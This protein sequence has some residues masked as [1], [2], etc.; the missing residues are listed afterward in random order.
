MDL[1]LFDVVIVLD[2]FVLLRALVLKDLQF[3]LQDFYPFLQLGQVLARV[4]NQVDVLVTCR[5]NLLVQRLEV[6]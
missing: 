6:L 3:V 5:F 1:E 4:L 2:G